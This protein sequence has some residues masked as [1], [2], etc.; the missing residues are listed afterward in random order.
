MAHCQTYNHLCTHLDGQEELTPPHPPYIP[1]L[2]KKK[3]TADRHPRGAP[4]P[5]HV[6][7]SAHWPRLAGLVGRG[8]GG[9]V[10]GGTPG[11]FINLSHP[12]TRVSDLV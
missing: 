3:N 7:I 11:P 1:K 4:S 2:K 10:S 9:G 12:C 8:S 5:C 6:P